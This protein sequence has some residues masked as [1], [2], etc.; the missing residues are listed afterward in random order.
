MKKIIKNSKLNK[1]NIR[2][3]SILSVIVI[4]L[5]LSVFGITNKSYATASDWEGY[6]TS[7]TDYG[8]TGN[9]FT[10]SSYF[11]IHLG[12]KGVKYASSKITLTTNANCKNSSGNTC[13]SS[14]L[15][16]YLNNYSKTYNFSSSNEEYV[17]ISSKS[18]GSTNI[19]YAGNTTDDGAFVFLAPEMRILIPKGYKE[20]STH[21]GHD[22]NLEDSALGFRAGKTKYGNKGYFDV[23]AHKGPF[24]KDTWTEVNEGILNINMCSAGL[25]TKQRLS[26]GKHR[27]T[28]E[29]Y[30]INFVPNKRTIEYN[31]NGGTGTMNNTTYT[32]NE[33]NTSDTNTYIKNNSFTRTNYRFLGWNTKADGSGTTY[34]EQQEIQATT[35]PTEDSTIKLYAQWEYDA[36]QNTYMSFFYYNTGTSVQRTSASCT[37]TGTSCDIT[38][39]SAVR[40]SVGSYNSSYAGLNN[41]KNNM[42]ATYTGTT[43]PSGGTYYAVYSSKVNNYYYDSGYKAQDLYRNQWVTGDGQLALSDPVLATTNTGMTNY[44]PITTG[45]G[46]SEWIGLST[47]ADETPEYNTVENAAKS[48]S[49]KLY[50]DYKMIVNYEKGTNTA[51]IGAETDNCTVYATGT[52]TGTT[53]C[54]VDLPSITPNTGDIVVGWNKTKDSETGTAPGQQYSITANNTTLYGNSRELDNGYAIAYQTNGGTLAENSP[55]YGTIGNDVIIN[56]PTKTVRITFNNSVGATIKNDSDQE[57]T[58][59]DVNLDFGGW[60]STTLSSTA[61]TGTSANPTSSW[62]GSKT[63]NTYF[64]DL[65]NNGGTVTMVANWDEKTV[66]LPSVDKQRST[67]SFNTKA[68]GTGTS[69]Q[70]HD[71]YTL[72]NNTTLYVVCTS[73]EQNYQIDYNLNNGDFGEYHPTTASYDNV[74]TISNPNKVYT[75]KSYKGNQALG[76]TTKQAEFLGWKGTNLSTGALTGTTETAVTNNW[77]TELTKN[78]YFK[79]LRDDTGTVT[80]EANWKATNIDL[81]YPEVEGEECQWYKEETF[82]NLIGNPGD[83]YTIEGNS[84][85][86]IK[87]YAKCTAKSFTV[88]YE[89]DS[90]GDI[91]KPEDQTEI[92]PFDGSPS[93]VE[94]TPHEG[95][96]TTGWTCNKDTYIRQGSSR[97][98]ITA[99]TLISPANFPTILVESDMKCTVHH[100]LNE[101]T[102]TLE[103]DENGKITGDL[104]KTVPYGQNI[105]NVKEEANEGYHS[106]GWTCDKKVTLN[107]NTEIEANKLMSQDNLLAAK[108]TSNMTCTAI[109]ERDTYNIQYDADEGINLDKKEE[110]VKYND[111]PT[112]NVKVENGYIFEKWVCDK[113]VELNNGK[114]IKTQDKISD[115]EMNIVKVKSNLSCKA[116]AEKEVVKKPA[117]KQRLIDKVV[118]NPYT[119]D[120]IRKYIAI[121]LLSFLALTAIILIK[122]DKKRKLNKVEEK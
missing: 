4:M 103:S 108:V 13:S 69:Y 116:L 23:E 110:N 87:I 62:S 59:L 40:N 57:I 91:T 64:M 115:S 35:W 42:T 22:S 122:E 14:E 26:D 15:Y 85:K 39:P 95:Y 48:T 27:R 71:N 30:S 88:E 52:T 50:S 10:S 75:I 78:R 66:P 28:W 43:V 24:D 93:E 118:K 99:E 106:I 113:D 119:G 5:T 11:Y 45:I 37:T 6:T 54:K 34:T 18:I 17:R 104:A 68:D 90:N 89:S 70:S 83:N 79:N 20:S 56:H 117:K 61:K 32:Y 2:I 60:T 3:A 120:K 21:H 1:K 107:D 8:S 47:A 53:S 102:V 84:Q 77:T 94:E 72:S 49:T 67:C 31:S 112:V 25:K 105:K 92:I 111:N 38:V 114:I 51:S 46:N 74:V 76:E 86:E 12:K 97:T 100:D 82:V 73:I 55:T 63:Q 101:Y 80:M 58:K 16:I 96:N 33:K 81:P 65:A 44:T 98:V 121:S 19:S 9:A 36:P 41:S 109:H 29:S 7:S